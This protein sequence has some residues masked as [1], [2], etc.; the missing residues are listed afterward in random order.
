M[1]NIKKNLSNAVNRYP[2]LTNY[3]IRGIDSLLKHL[4]LKPE[5]FRVVHLNLNLQRDNSP[6]I[7]IKYFL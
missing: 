4:N 3:F 5:Q 7:H 2:L 1:L 6:K